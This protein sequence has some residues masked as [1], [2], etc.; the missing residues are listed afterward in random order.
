MCENNIL[1]LSLIDQV[2]A[3]SMIEYLRATRG[4]RHDQ[5]STLWTVKAISRVNVSVDRFMSLARQFYRYSIELRS[6]LHWIPPITCNRGPT[7]SLRTI[8]ASRCV[9][10]IIISLYAQSLALPSI[11][12]RECS[13]EGCASQLRPLLSRNNRSFRVTGRADGSLENVTSRLL[14]YRAFES[15]QSAASHR[16]ARK[17]RTVLKLRNKFS[18]EAR[19]ARLGNE[20]RRI[21]V[22]VKYFARARARAH[23]RLI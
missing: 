10:V 1:R 17:R 9:F 23:S 20:A 21:R 13:R 22:V 19:G 7:S 18:G 4:V 16:S 15:V 5:R 6:E 14:I 11:P 8:V 3:R 2:T 12:R